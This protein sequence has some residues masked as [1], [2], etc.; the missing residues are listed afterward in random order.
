MSAPTPDVSVR[1]IDLLGVRDLLIGDLVSSTVLQLAVYDI[2]N[3]G[4]EAIRF[5]VVDE[6]GGVISL[7]CRDVVLAE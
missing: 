4:L 6:E 7:V 1:R 2:S 3:R 5:R